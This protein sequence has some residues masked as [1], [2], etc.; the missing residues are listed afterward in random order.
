MPKSVLH[1]L[2]DKDLYFGLAISSHPVF[3][4]KKVLTLINICVSMCANLGIRADLG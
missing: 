1:Y 3:R 2:L 4:L